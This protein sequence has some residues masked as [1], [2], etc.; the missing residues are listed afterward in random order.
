M[1]DRIDVNR[2]LVEMRAMKNQAQA[3]GNV[4]NV[5]VS[6]SSRV[7]PNEGVNGPR[8]NDVLA[9]AV[10]KVN[11]VQQASKAMSN[12]YLQGDSN[13]DVT[14]VM[15]AS[16]KASVAFESMVQVRNKLVEAYRDV[17]NM[18]I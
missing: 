2:L 8:F 15:I 4:N 5:D 11:E 17:M 9:S 18:P 13:I 7:A 10:D 6:S 1:T 3:F 16:Q 14:D 12:A